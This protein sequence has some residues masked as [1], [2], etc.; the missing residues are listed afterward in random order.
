MLLVLKDFLLGQR[1]IAVSMVPIQ[2]NTIVYGSSDAG[3]TIHASDSK[4]ND[5]MEKIAK[6]LNIKSHQVGNCTIYGPGD[7]EVD[8]AL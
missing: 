6:L 4:L 5:R 3:R 7:I 8:I 2:K 1:L